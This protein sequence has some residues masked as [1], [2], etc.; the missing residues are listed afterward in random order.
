MA[1][2]DNLYW[3]GHSCFY[4]KL[5][6]QVIFID[7]FMVSDQIKEKADVILITHPH[8][9]HF[10]IDDI[11]KI[12]KPTTKI[13]ASQGCQGIEKYKNLHVLKPYESLSLENFSVSTLPA[14]NIKK[15]RLKN[16][17]KDKEWL[18]YLVKIGNE[19]LYHAGDTDFI[20]EMEELNGGIDISI[21]PIGGTYTM[22]TKEAIAA[23]S[24]INAKITIPMHYKA[25][26]GKDGSMEAESLFAKGLSSAKIMKEIQQPH[27]SFSY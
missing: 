7:P 20:P 13:I 16:H 17:P 19:T 9:D 12:I 14:Y 1:I 4:I 27:Y 11:D 3:V 18:G 15:E 21:L 8:F 2:I 26:L 24:A 5:E 6:G 25:L 10:S 22:D 23:A